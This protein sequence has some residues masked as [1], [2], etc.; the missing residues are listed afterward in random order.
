VTLHLRKKVLLFINFGLFLWLFG[1][2]ITPILAASGIPPGQKIAAFAYFFYQPVC[3]QMPDRSFWLVGFTLAV[4][5]RCFSFY[6]GGFLISLFYLLK[7]RI[8]M[9]SFSIYILLV[10]PAVIDFLLEKLGFYTNAI[11][12]RIITGL[13]LGLAIFHLF[14]ASVSD[15]EKKQ[16][17][18]K[19]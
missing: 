17:I 14:L 2:I 9:W 8:Q 12:L 19:T 6:L 13:L 1:I 7:D 5:V 4:C 18:L 15:I 16:E 3:H 11:D 10:V